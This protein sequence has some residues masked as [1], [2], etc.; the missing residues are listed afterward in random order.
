MKFISAEKMR[1]LEEKLFDRG[2]SVTELMEKVGR[3]C[4]E[5]IESKKGTGNRVLVFCGPGNNG[6]DGLVCARYLKDNN[7]VGI[8][9]A[10]GPKTVEAKTN[11]RRAREAGIPLVR[12]ENAK[13]FRADIVIDALLGIGAEGP[14]RGKIKKACSAVHSMGGFIVSI[15]VP[16]GAGQENRVKPDATLAI[17]APKAEGGEIWTVD[18]GIPKE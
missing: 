18:I 1:A 17:H 16:T 12:M 3:K 4:A 13:D 11:Y 2:I 8:V 14:L 7:I 9:M 10:G 5:T 15:D 6:G